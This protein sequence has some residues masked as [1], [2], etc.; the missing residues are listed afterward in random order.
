MSEL[1]SLF[2]RARFKYCQWE[3]QIQV[4]SNL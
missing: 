3:L 1:R 2:Y 4:T